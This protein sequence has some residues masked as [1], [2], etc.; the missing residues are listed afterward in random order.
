M[1]AVAATAPA[2]PS[3]LMLFAAGLG[4]RMRPLSDSR[5]KPLI[6][7]AGRAL[8]DHALDQRG[9]LPLRCVANAHYRADQLA[10]HLQGGDVTLSREEQLLDTGGGLRA[11]LPLLGPGPV[12]TLNTD[13][14]WQGPAALPLLAR[15]WDP[16]RME[17]LLLCIPPERAL[18]H[19]G[20]GDFLSDAQGRG[21]PGPGAI[22][23]GAQI[24]KPE[25][26]GEIDAPAFSLTEAW[27]RMIDRGTLY[28]AA[29]PGLWCDVGQPDS[30]TLAEDMLAEKVPHD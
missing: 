17:A 18:G 11:A 20:Q 27:R 26:L 2:Q 25:T 24:L 6:K 7:V 15:H 10:A 19:A 14:V 21:R 29:Y 1:S 3:A 9:T 5:P 4:T 13:A 28:L 12:F 22:Y 8:I 23:T 16:A 30:I